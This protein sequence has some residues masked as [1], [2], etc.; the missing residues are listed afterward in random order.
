MEEDYSD[1]KPLSDSESEAGDEKLEDDPNYSDQEWS[2]EPSSEDNL[3][4]DSE[5][6]VSM[7]YFNSLITSLTFF[8]FKEESICTSDDD[9]DWSDRKQS[10][11]RKFQKVKVPPLTSTGTLSTSGFSNGVGAELVPWLRKNFRLSQN[12]NVI[13]PR[14]HL[15]S[16]YTRFCAENNMTIVNS[17][18]LGKVL[19]RTF[20]G[21]DTRRLGRR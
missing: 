16:K 1:C 20:P 10:S 8:E 5:D 14:S 18:C 15:Y 7:K 2:P 12:P 6:E 3:L 13:I 19:R 4:E 9:E 21:V 11:A 17:A